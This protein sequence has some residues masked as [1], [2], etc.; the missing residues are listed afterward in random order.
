MVSSNGTKRNATS[1][2][3]PSEELLIHIVD[4]LKRNH[5]A[6]WNELKA[7]EG[8]DAGLEGRVG[9]ELSA[10]LLA[11]TTDLDSFQRS[12]LLLRVRGRARIE[13]GLRA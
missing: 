11:A 13:A 1:Y 8:R 12:I 3:E 5:E 7:I 9:H 6:L 10:A 2:W 4:I